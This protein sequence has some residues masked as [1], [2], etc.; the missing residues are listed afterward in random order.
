[1]EEG[2]NSKFKEFLSS[3]GLDQTKDI[4]IKYK[5]KAADFYRRILEA[6][7]SNKEFNEDLPTYTEGRFLLDG[8]NLDAN[9][10]IVENLSAD[11][12]A[13]YA[14]APK[15]NSS[16]GSEKTETNNDFEKLLKRGQDIIAKEE[17][18]VPNFD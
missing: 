15:I 11:E 2:G 7:V 6:E 4:K 14:N 5:T 1:M 10:N 9:G 13:M 18:K 12:I 8:R 17:S 3:F 16:P